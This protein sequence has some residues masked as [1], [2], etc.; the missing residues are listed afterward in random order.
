[1][2]RIVGKPNLVLAITN[3]TITEGCRPREEAPESPLRLPAGSRAGW[4]QALI[5]RGGCLGVMNPLAQTAKSGRAA[6]RDLGTTKQGFSDGR[7]Y[8]LGTSGKRAFELG[9]GQAD[10]CAR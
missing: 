7:A 8:V 10:R 9:L 6:G 2:N 1:V 5:V 3:L 4:N